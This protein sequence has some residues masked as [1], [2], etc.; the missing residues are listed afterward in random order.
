[1]R[2]CMTNAGHAEDDDLSGIV[3]TASVPRAINPKDRSA[4]ERSAVYLIG[5]ISA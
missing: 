5:G 3:A 4:H 2:G 1:M